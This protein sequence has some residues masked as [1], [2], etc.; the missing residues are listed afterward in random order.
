MFDFNFY[1]D[2]SFRYFATL[3]IE[4][5]LLMSIITIVVSDVLIEKILA[6]VVLVIV[7]I[8]PL[9]SNTGLYPI[10]NNL[11]LV[12]PV[13]LWMVWNRLFQGKCIREVF[14]DFKKL[15]PVKWMLSLLLIVITIQSICF[16]FFFVYC[17]IGFPF[18]SNVEF[19]ENNLL[20]GMRSHS[21][22]VDQ[23]DKLTR[24]V[25]DQGLTGKSCITFGHIPGIHYI[26]EMPFALSHAWPDLGSYT[27][28]EMKEDIE[29]LTEM[30]IVF[31][32][33]NYYSDILSRDL[34]GDDKAALLVEYMIAHDYEDVFSTDVITVYYPGSK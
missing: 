9:G 26:M 19:Q 21:Y 12:A 6:I 15:L 27:L 30:P 17:D 4:I 2:S 14:C 7:S 18:G 33:N 29:A 13:T 5:A 31:V 10:V 3:F 24:F 25:Y 11:F 20:T 8:T 32:S 34:K 22:R 1:S 16:G 23:I 28:E